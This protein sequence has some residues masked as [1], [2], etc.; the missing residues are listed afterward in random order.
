MTKT[1]S[2]KVKRAERAE[3]NRKYRA[4][5]RDAGFSRMEIWVP[6]AEREAWE[7]TKQKLYAKWQPPLQR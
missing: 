5:L 7:Q 2:D 6:N 3:R 1:K 4:Q